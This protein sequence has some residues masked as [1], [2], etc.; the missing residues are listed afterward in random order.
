MVL[1]DIVWFDLIWIGLGV[2][3]IVVSAL[4][5]LH[6]PRFGLVLVGCGG[7]MALFV[8]VWFDLIWAERIGG[9]RGG[10]IVGVAVASCALVSRREPSSSP[11]QQQQR[12]QRGILT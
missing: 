3:S 12:P 1:F 5:S 7:H 8:I 11:K 10:H 2:V 6:W 4:V 9:G